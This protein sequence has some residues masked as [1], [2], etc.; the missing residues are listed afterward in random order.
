MTGTGAG[1]VR[2]FACPIL[3]SQLFLQ[4]KTL[5]DIG[6]FV[7]ASSCFHLNVFLLTSI[8]DEIFWDADCRQEIQTRCS[9]R[10]SESL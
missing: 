7:D 8:F 5:D 6:K 3:N 1:A 9:P 4:N 2:F 10:M